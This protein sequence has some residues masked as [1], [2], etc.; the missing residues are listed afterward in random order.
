MTSLKTHF[1]LAFFLYVM[2]SSSISRGYSYCVY[3]RAKAM[4]KDSGET[5][6]NKEALGLTFFHGII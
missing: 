2:S 4:H 6:G 1:P 5:T 3:S